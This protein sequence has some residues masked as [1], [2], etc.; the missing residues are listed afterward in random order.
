[1]KPQ[2][3]QHKLNTAFD[4][5]IEDLSAIR[6]NRAQT[7][8]IENIK[9]DA[10]PGSSPLTVKE[11]GSIIVIGAQMLAVEVWDATIA[12]S[13]AKA[14]LNSG[15]GLNPVVDGKMIKIPIPQLTGDRRQ[16]LAKLVSQKVEEAKIAVRNI[17]HDAFGAIEEQKEN[18]VLS[19]DEY[20]KLKKD[21]DEMVGEIN[22]KLMAKGK[23]KEQGILNI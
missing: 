10:Y 2:E 3:F 12:D 6:G 5:L 9:V 19:E 17:R 23:E 15:T 18:N 20:F 16:E 7:S 21:Y 13:V 14:I 1:M 8:L 22:T 11:L 4:H